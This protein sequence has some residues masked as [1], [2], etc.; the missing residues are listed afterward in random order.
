MW[1]DPYRWKGKFVKKKVYKAMV[2]RVNNG[3]N[4]KKVHTECSDDH[5]T[6]NEL[7]VNVQGN[8]V[9]NLQLMASEMFCSNCNEPLLLQNIESEIIRGLASVFKIRCRECLLVNTVNTGEKYKNPVTDR[10]IF[11]INTKAA[12]G[13]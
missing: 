5:E 13:K 3:R 2:Q 7:L 12:L 11:S 10:P 9:V 8:R 4:R 6:S 1:S